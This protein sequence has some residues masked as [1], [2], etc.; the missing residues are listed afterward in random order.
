MMP[1]ASLN[2]LVLRLVKGKRADGQ[3]LPGRLCSSELGEAALGSGDEN[4]EAAAAA[5]GWSMDDMDCLARSIE[6]DVAAAG[7]SMDDVAAMLDL[8][9]SPQKASPPHLPP[10]EQA[11][12]HR[13]LGQAHQQHTQAQQ[14]QA[15]QTRQQQSEQHNPSQPNKHLLIAAEVER[16]G[17]TSSGRASKRPP[18]VSDKPCVQETFEV[19]VQ[20]LSGESIPLSCNASDPLRS[21]QQ[22]LE[23]L[24]GITIPEQRLALV[25]PE[26]DPL[27]LPAGG[28][29]GS[30]SSLGI[31][32]RA[33]LKL[34]A[35]VDDIVVSDAAD[36]SHRAMDIQAWR[37]TNAEGD[38]CTA[39]QRA[40]FRKVVVTV[41][42]SVVEIAF[43][44]DARFVKLIKRVGG[45]GK[46]RWQGQAKGGVWTIAPVYL[47]HLLELFPGATVL[48][49]PTESAT[50]GAKNGVSSSQLLDAAELDQK[51][52]NGWTLFAHQKEAVVEILQKRRQIL[53]YDMGL[54]KTIISL[55]AAKAWQ[56]V[57]NGAILVICP[58]SVRSSWEAEAEMV[59]VVIST[60]SWGSVPAPPPRTGSAGFFLVADE[61]HYMQNMESKRTVAALKLCASAGALVLATG[62]PL[63]NA[64]PSNL[65]PLLR[66]VKHPL[67]VDQRGYEVRYCNAR[68]TRFNP[69]DVSGA[70]NL[71]EL[72]DKIK[73]T[74]LRKTKEQVL[75]LPG[76]TRRR[77]DLVPTEEQ[78]N[79]Y[80]AKLRHAKAVAKGTTDRQQSGSSRGAGGGNGEMSALMALRQFASLSKVEAAAELAAQAVAAGEA[81]CICCCFVETARLVHRNITDGGI[82]CELLTGETKQSDRGMMV[83]RF[84]RGGSQAFV[85]TAG[86]GG[87]GIT[88]TAASTI[89]LVDRA[90]TPGDVEQVE[91][92]LNRIGQLQ[93]VKC[94][95]LRLFEVC[96]IVDEMLEKKQKKINN[97]LGE[98]TTL[99]ADETNGIS[100]AAVLEQL[101]AEVVEIPSSPKTAPNPFER[102]KQ[103]AAASAAAARDVLASGETLSQF[104][105]HGTLP[106]VYCG[107]RSATL[108]SAEPGDV[109]G[110]A[111]IDENQHGESSDICSD[112]A[113]DEWEQVT[114]L[115]AAAERTRERK[116]MSGDDAGETSCNH[117]SKSS[118]QSST[119]IRHSCSLISSSDEEDDDNDIVGCTSMVALSDAERTRSPPLARYHQHEEG[120]DSARAPM[121]A[122]NQLEADPS[123]VRLVDMGFTTAQAAAALTEHPGNPEGALMWLL[124]RARCAKEARQAKIAAAAAREAGVTASHS[125]T[126]HLLQQE[127]TH[128]A[129]HSFKAACGP[130]PRSPSVMHASPEPSRANRPCTMAQQDESRASLPLT[131]LERAADENSDPQCSA[132]DDDTSAQMRKLRLTGPT[133]SNYMPTWRK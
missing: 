107:I 77:H 78:R 88:L 59:D 94:I 49:S 19:H 80:N 97:V 65:F 101:F 33:A 17:N 40:Q 16:P 86:A 56:R 124:N 129:G 81:V 115:A 67:A 6:E 132:G 7:W 51:L 102:A 48:Q 35:G 60:H 70:A 25:L 32:G 21:L 26:S 8:S 46:A 43:P 103:V 54:G 14:A 109:D 27:Q 128:I 11:Q 126:R 62:T 117:S 18:Q 98:N 105:S 2:G 114:R 131:K 89:I 106:G 118:S 24:T 13:R 119:E 76:K 121:T 66:A 110:I 120:T 44:Y 55:V 23:A 61:A 93:L 72:H 34:S 36:G 73:G 47:S 111:T 123:I 127:P 20:L 112:S 5:A 4:L 116:I 82:K 104:P 125:R 133:T 31:D 100:A 113:A 92:R 85:F 22:R 37:F 3:L 41:K 84:Q 9:M 122:S 53:A 28:I 69:W 99:E 68:K 42:E 64:R 52:P 1:S 63:K 74:I 79:E 130:V 71:E 91:D 45:G 38:G 90:M 39:K 96:K 15:T 12:T 108:D 95:W 29:G 58:V 50:Q 30:L 10:H 83:D 87:V 57:T 75:E